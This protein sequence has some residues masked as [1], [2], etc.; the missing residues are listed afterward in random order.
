MSISILNTDTANISSLTRCFK[1]FGVHPL[2]ANNIDECISNSRKI[3]LPW[4]WKYEVHEQIQK[5][6]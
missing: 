3:I 6:N 2:I 5:R 1:K 4:Y